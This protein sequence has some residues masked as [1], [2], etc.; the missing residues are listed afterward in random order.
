[1][2]SPFPG[3]NPFLETPE[4]WGDFHAALAY[5]IRVQLTPRLRPK[6]TATLVPRIE[7]NELFIQET[8]ALYLPRCGRVRV[9]AGQR[10]AALLCSRFRQRR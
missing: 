6:Y 7:V 8:T 5:E 9:S 2:P 1:M 3:M 4:L 10:A